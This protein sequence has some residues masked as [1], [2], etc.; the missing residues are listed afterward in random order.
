MLY[1]RWLGVLTIIA[2]IAVAAVGCTKASRVEPGKA[3]ASR[4]SKTVNTAKPPGITPVAVYYLKMTARDLYLVR[5]VHE[6]QRTPALARAA[7]Q[8][9]ISGAPKTPG[10]YRVLPEETKILGITVKQGLATVDFSK[11]VLW[12]NVGSAGEA[13]GIQSIVN[14]LTEF[15]SIKKVAFRVEGK[16]DEAAMNW[17]GHVGLYGQPFKRDLSEVYEPVIWVYRPQ[18]GQRVTSPLIVTGS[19]RVFEATVQVRLLDGEKRVITS[20]SGM[21]TAGAPERGEFTIKL[22][23]K[24]PKTDKGYL[25][26]FWPSPKDGS[27]LDVVRIPLAFK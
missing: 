9:L 11:E 3:P 13:L 26:V 27:P 20:A 24:P 12:A 4:Q 21:A 19:A 1:R 23:F 17:W 8:E 10:A 2:L 5:E 16:L 18:P 6:V 22:E 25:E 15:P 7:L 14:T